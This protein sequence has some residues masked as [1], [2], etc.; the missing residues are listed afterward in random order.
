MSERVVYVWRD[1][2]NGWD[3][4]LE[5]FADGTKQAS[6]RPHPGATWGPPVTL[7]RQSGEVSG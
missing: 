5:M 3:W 2:R 6:T 4:M 1:P 7:V